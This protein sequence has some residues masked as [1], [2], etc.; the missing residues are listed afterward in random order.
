M[1]PVRARARARCARA[2]AD[3]RSL[4]ARGMD[5]TVLRLPGHGTLPS[6]MTEMSARDWTAAVRIAAKDVAARV[7]AGRGPAP[8]GPPTRY[9]HLHFIC[10]SNPP[11]RR[12]A[13]AGADVGCDPFP[14]LPPRR[15]CCHDAGAGADP[16]PPSLDRRYNPPFSPLPHA[17]ARVRARVPPPPPPLLQPCFDAVRA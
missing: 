14:P 5:V 9:P 3:A 15:R 10:R 1:C 8:P 2:R 16:L 11:H 17:L 13:S 6:M 7:G 12:R 4:H